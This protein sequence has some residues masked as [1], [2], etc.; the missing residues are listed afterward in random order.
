MASLF[1]SIF[2]LSTF[3]PRVIYDSVTGSNANE[4][5]VAGKSFDYIIVGGGLSGLTVANRLSEDSSRR[6]NV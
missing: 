5:N 3:V 6:C 1:S 4:V 2:Y